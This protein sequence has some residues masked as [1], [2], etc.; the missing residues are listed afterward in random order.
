VEHLNHLI[1]EFYIHPI[2]GIGPWKLF[3]IDMTPSKA[4]I[5]MWLAVILVFLILFIASRRV[6]LIPKKFQSLIE[7]A[8]EFV[9]NDII[10]TMMGAGNANWFPLLAALFFFILFCNLLGLIPF[11]F[12]PT[13]SINVTATL[14]IMVF[15]IVQFTGT[16]KHNPVGYVKSW[17]PSG[18]PVGIAVIMF[19]I[20]LVSQLVKP[21]SLAVRLFANMLAGHLVLGSFLGLILLSANYLIAPFPLAGA[22]VIYVLELLFAFIQAYVFTFL[23]AMYIGDALHGH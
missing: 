14:A 19:P 3:G 20:E 13:S 2:K 15:I 5:V 17:V 9:N 4:V 6:R 10:V 18:I 21:F 1:E 12:T 22:I 16:K 8:F 23:T 7:I 11:S